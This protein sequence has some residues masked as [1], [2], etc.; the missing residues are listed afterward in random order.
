MGLFHLLNIDHSVK[1][2]IVKDFLSSAVFRTRSPSPLLS[3]YSLD[4]AILL[5]VL[6]L[7][8]VVEEW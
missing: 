5:S 1:L 7:R 6:V 4:G 8:A 2:P 3:L